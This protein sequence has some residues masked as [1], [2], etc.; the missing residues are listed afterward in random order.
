M[1]VYQLLVEEQLRAGRSQVREFTQGLF[2]AEAAVLVFVIK[3]RVNPRPQPILSRA[4]SVVITI[5][6]HRLS[7]FFVLRVRQAGHLF[8]TRAIQH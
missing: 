1:L 6:Q 7:S 3:G 4:H 2:E 8:V 5:L